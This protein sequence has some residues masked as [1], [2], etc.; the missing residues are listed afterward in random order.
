MIPQMLSD[1]LIKNLENILKNTQNLKHRLITTDGVFS[2]DG[3]IAELIVICELAKKYDA[4]LH[5]LHLTTEKEMAL[6]SNKHRSE[7]R[8]TA[9]VCVHHLWF[10]ESDYAEHGTFIKC[11]PAIK[12]KADKLA[13]QKAL[14]ETK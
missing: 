13:L 10:E 14:K 7:K 11:N 2:M 5:V 8:V 4:L 3:Y 12:S 1:I 6:F 9:E